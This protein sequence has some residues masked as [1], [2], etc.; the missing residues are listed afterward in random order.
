MTIYE[1]LQI[2]VELLSQTREDRIFYGTLTAIMLLGF[3]YTV[4]VF[5]RFF[6]DLV[7]GE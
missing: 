1:R 6:I 7:K 2:L 5:V 3:I 4:G